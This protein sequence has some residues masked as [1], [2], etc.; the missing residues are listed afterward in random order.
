MRVPSASEILLLHDYLIETTG[1]EHG[2]RDLQA[3]EAAVARPFAGFGDVELFPNVHDKA[4]ALADSIINYHPFVD[5]NKRTGVSSAGIVLS[6]NGW[7][8]TATNSELVWFGRHV[9][10]ARPEV[11][12]T[13]AWLSDHSRPIA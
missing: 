9:A 1:G 5:G 4:A 8:M 2:V 10:V 13:A 7:E 3:L 11:A 12:E 6:L